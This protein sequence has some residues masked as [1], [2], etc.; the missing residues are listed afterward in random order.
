M[1][2]MMMGGDDRTA[3]HVAVMSEY[4]QQ[5]L[6][7]IRRNNEYLVSLG[8]SALSNGRETKVGSW[9]SAESGNPLDKAALPLPLPQALAARP[10]RK[11][12]K[13]EQKKGLQAP[14]RRRSSRLTGQQPQY[15]GELI[16]RFFDHGGESASNGRRTDRRA[17]SRS[18]AVVKA[19]KT[20]DRREQSLEHLAST[21][22][23]SREWLA[24]GRKALLQV[25]SGVSNSKTGEAASNAW[26]QEAVRRWGQRV[27][28]GTAKGGIDWEV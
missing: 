27:P 18:I 22:D 17:K 19:E 8:L 5:R 6:E 16:D 14:T 13:K 7:H 10:A 3:P 15:T 20:L 9:P 4:E 2:M 11:R 25:G 12:V 1:M 28:K 24:A 21:L 23:L 26:R